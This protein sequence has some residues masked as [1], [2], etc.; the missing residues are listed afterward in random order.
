MERGH[1]VR[2]TGR[3]RLARNILQNQ[4]HTK[5]LE[6]MAD[7]SFCSIRY[8]CNCL[9]QDS[10]E[11]HNAYVVEICGPRLQKRLGFKTVM[12]RTVFYISTTEKGGIFDKA[13]I[14]PGFIPFGYTH[15]SESG[16]YSQLEGDRGGK[17]TLRFVEAAPNGNGIIHRIEIEVPI[18]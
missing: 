15:G 1:L 11:L 10:P 13:G 14:K 17:T 8:R 18:N 2:I 5:I 16:F 12:D 9:L 7:F 4:F 6:T 3:G